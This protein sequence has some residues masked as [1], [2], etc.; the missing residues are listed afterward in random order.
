MNNNCCTNCFSVSEIK[1]LI[2]SEGTIGNCDYCN[3]TD[4]RI[5]D[6]RYVGNFIKEGVERYYEDAANQVGYCSSEGGYLLPTQDMYDILLE[7]E[8]IFGEILDGAYSLLKDLIPNDGIPY[9]RKDP[10][11]PPSGD[12]DEIRYWENFCNVVK[13][14][15]RFT[16][17][18]TSDDK[19]QRYDISHPSS[20]LDHLANNFMPSLIKEISPGSRIYRARINGENREF[21]NEDLTSPPPQLSR[22]SRMSPTGI[23]FFYGGLDSQVCIHEV[24]PSIAE[25]V[26]VGEFEVIKKIFVLDL[27]TEI[28]ARRSIFDSEYV[29]TYEEYFK[30]FLLHFIQDISKPIRKADTHIEYIPTQVF[31]EFIKAN[32]FKKDY[33]CPDEEGN[34]RDVFVNGIIFKSSIM[35]EGTNL[36]LFRG[37]DI[38]TA[39][40]DDIRD[41]WLLYKS[42]KTYQITEINV[43]SKI[44]EAQR[45]E[46]SVSSDFGHKKQ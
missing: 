20:F 36:V 33:Y 8:D 12:P 30:P 31:T 28:E 24:H 2:E 14:Q 21:S 5:F 16:I 43:N 7:E 17:F 18:L 27:T 22:N 15:K 39:D 6:V 32:N 42:K 26:A 11:G 13:T 25:N 4:V 34:E 10:Y 37:S 46:I 9:V 44:V 38:S 41:T 1:K 29:F 19:S 40:S 45:S 23:S 3:S 35:K